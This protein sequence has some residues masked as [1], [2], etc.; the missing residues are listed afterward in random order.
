MCCN[1]QHHVF[2]Y[3]VYLQQEVPAD[4]HATFLS[5]H[6][7]SFR[8]LHILCGARLTARTPE[9]AGIDREEEGSISPT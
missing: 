3:I 8:A 5:P 6:S 9:L 4:F 7:G 2:L 1:R